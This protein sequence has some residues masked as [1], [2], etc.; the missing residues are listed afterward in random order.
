M[1]CDLPERPVEWNHTGQFFACPLF[2]PEKF[3]K[4][5]PSALVTLVKKIRYDYILAML[6]KLLFS[7]AIVR[8]LLIS[9]T[10]VVEQTLKLVLPV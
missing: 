10:Q 3:T 9:P 7:A 4:K 2:R 5:T 1:A 8:G 6:Q